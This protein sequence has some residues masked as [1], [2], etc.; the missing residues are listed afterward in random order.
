MPQAAIAETDPKKRRLLQKRQ[1]TAHEFDTSVDSIK[2]L[3]REGLLT[4]IR[5][6]KS[7]KADVYH[8]AE[9]VT[10][11]KAKLFAA[12][13]AEREAKVER[14]RPAKKGGR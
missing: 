1:T 8:D 12:A 14:R 11:L 7:P 2:R 4:P 5:L 9:E 13:K 10:A 6:F 3:E